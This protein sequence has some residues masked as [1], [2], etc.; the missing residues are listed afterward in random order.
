MFNPFVCCTHRDEFF[1]EWD[2]FK[3][4]II[5]CKLKL[6]SGSSLT[7]HKKLVSWGPRGV[8]NYVWKSHRRRINTEEKAKVIVA[9]LG[10][11][12]IK[13]LDALA[14]LKNRMSSSY[15]F[16][17]SCCSSFYFW[18]IQCN[19]ASAARSLVNSAPQTEA[20]T[21]AMFF[22]LYPSSM[23]KVFS[24]QKYPQCKHIKWIVFHVGT[25]CTVARKMWAVCLFIFS[26][27]E[28]QKAHKTLQCFD[29]WAV[30]LIRIRIISRILTC[31]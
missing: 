19:S 21:F 29:R 2:R 9:V 4:P 30:L 16:K 25:V 23:E 18:I 31:F 6:G 1:K 17:S 13:F 11:K 28:N 7:A 20:T 10:G 26:C 12:I 27:W 5:Q 15:C 8:E 24:A 22:C 3:S 14:I